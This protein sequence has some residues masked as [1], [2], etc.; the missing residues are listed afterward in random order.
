ML[1]PLWLYLLSSANLSN[2][3]LLSIP[4][5]YHTA[6]LGPEPWCSPIDHLQQEV[7]KSQSSG[8]ELIIKILP[9]LNLATHYMTSVGTS[10]GFFSTAR[11]FSGLGPDKS[12]PRQRYSKRLLRAADASGS[13]CEHAAYFAWKQRHVS[14]AAAAATGVESHL[15]VAVV[16]FI[17]PFILVTAGAASLCLQSFLLP[18]VPAL[19]FPFPSCGH[20]SPSAPGAICF[21]RS[22]EE[23]VEEFWDQASV[24]TD[25]QGMTI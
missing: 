3:A 13:D 12:C 11:S 18:L 20:S 17:P 25:L 14:Q 19:H 9:T 1:S 22:A 16:A 21:A 6:Q 4:K 7:L 24:F 2:E 10:V 15:T 5:N 23:Q 8:C